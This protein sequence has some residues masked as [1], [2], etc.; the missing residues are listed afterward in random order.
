[1]RMNVQNT[2]LPNNFQEIDNNLMLNERIRWILPDKMFEYELNRNN[3]K[4]Q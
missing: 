1:M 4:I 3:K 2:A